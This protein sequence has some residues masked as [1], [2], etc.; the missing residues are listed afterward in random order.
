MDGYAVRAADLAGARGERRAGS[1]SRSR[2]R[3]AAGAAGARGGRGGAH[4]HRRAAAA[5]RR[6]RRASGGRRG[7]TARRCA[8][9]AAA[10]ARRERARGRRGRARGRRRCSRRDAARAGAARDARVARPHASC[11]SIAGRA[12][13]ILSGGDELVE[14]RRGRRAAAASSR[15][16]R[17]R[18]RRSAARWARSATNLGIARDTPRRA[19]ARCCAPASA[20]DVLVS[21]AP[22]S[23]SA[24]TTTCARC[25]R[26]SAARLDFWGVQMKPG[27]PLV[28]RPRR[29]TAR[30]P[31]VFGLPGNPVSA[32][33]TFELF[34]RPLL[35]RLG[36][37]RA[38]SR[39]RGSTRCSREAL[40]KK[41]AAL[42]Y[43]RVHARARSGERLVARST[44]NQSSGVLRSMAL[45][46]GA[47]RVPGRRERARGRRDGARA[48]CSTTTSLPRAEPRRERERRGPRIANVAAALLLGG[49]ST[50]MGA[51][52]GAAPD[53]RRARGDAAR[54]AARVR[55]SRT[56]CSSAAM[57][58]ASALGR[59]V[60]DAARPA[61]RAARSR[62]RARGRARRA[63][64]RGRD[65]SAGDHARSA[66]R[67]GRVRPRPTSWCRA[68]AAG[69]SRSARSIAASPRSPRR[70]QRSPRVG[71]RCTSCSTRLDV[72][73][74]EGA[75]LAA[76]DPDGRALANVNTP[77]ELRAPPQRSEAAR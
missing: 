30:A 4:L 13:A 59:R 63:R 32:M 72:R 25:S 60:A 61:L 3:R 48:A 17:T 46:A 34:V 9:R 26:S 57:P 24:I 22:A 41:P 38:C 44:G 69:A 68:R 43:V 14:P 42:H 11:A 66:A 27:Y 5:G 39:G 58:P 51:R 47:A 12:V 76:V 62:R 45:A 1:P 52:Q 8:F 2:W 70:A 50:R 35:L 77:A 31:F 56:C 64:A 36:G 54:R 73:W 37:T 71:S 55:S 23:R 65:R 21:S 29:A 6:Q 19:R 49:A 15:R 74:L 33:V 28:V 53:R 18:S 40:R 16:T 20:R 75:D 67:A 10:R 7:A